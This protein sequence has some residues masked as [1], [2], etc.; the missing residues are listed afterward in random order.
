M[1]DLADEPR[2]KIQD[3]IPRKIMHAG[4]PPVNRK[5]LISRVM[6]GTTSDPPFVWIRCYIL[7][8][9]SCLRCCDCDQ[10]QF[11]FMFMINKLFVLWKIYLCKGFL[12]NIYLR[13]IMNLF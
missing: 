3:E 12:D 2:E 11:L 6:L 7:R 9:D 4:N 13:M 1:E 5:T 8:D 10:R